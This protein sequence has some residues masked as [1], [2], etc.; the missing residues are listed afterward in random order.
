MDFKEHIDFSNKPLPENCGISC[1]LYSFE[2]DKDLDFS[3]DFDVKKCLECNYFKSFL[4][5]AKGRR[6]ADQ[7][8]S[9]FLML[10]LERISSYAQQ[11]EKVGTDLKKRVEELT[12]LKKVSDALLKSKDLDGSLKLILTGVTAGEAFGFN[13][14]FIFLLNEKNNLLEGKMA[15]GP[16]TPEEAEKIWSELKKI[17]FDQ[18]LENISNERNELTELVSQISVPL[19]EKNSSYILKTFREKKS[20]NLKTPDPKQIGDKLLSEILDP[21][22]FALVPV[23]YEDKA[24]G[25][26]IVDNFITHQNITDEDVSALETFANQVAYQI[27]NI[28]LQKKLSLK[29]QELKHI[30]SL[31]RENQEYLL[32]HERLAD[33]GRLA[34]TCAHELKTP[35][36]AIGGYARRAMKKMQNHK[37]ASVSNLEELKVIIDEVERLETITSEILDYSKDFKLKLEDKDINHIIN[38]AIE[39]LEENLR[40]NNIRV[41]TDFS[42]DLGTV[43]VD[44]SRLKQALFNLIENACEAMFEG[45]T[46]SLRTQRKDKFVVVEIKDS[47][48]GIPEKDIK[49]LFVPFFTTK[50]NGSGLG[51]S[52]TKKI[53]EQ[54]Q[55]FIQVQSKPGEGTEFLVYLP[56]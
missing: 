22:G 55:G 37:K 54:H 3:F 12:I 2:Q 17:T 43:K 47:G 50:P 52:V 27:A 13:R 6:F 38:E 32:K 16:K 51:L 15:L 46:L 25:I 39:I 30:N 41:K 48:F 35:L 1:W 4:S 14:A 45:G 18:I 31:L 8:A 33:I 40:Y 44:S 11:L 56:F 29:L 23:L 49:M 7:K 19:D 24:I 53:I 5:R 9:S 28:L 42:E 34:T 20:Y 26:L 36:V 21:A 10:F